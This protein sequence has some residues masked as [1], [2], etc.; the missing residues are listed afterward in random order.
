M[1]SIGRLQIHQTDH[2]RQPVATTDGI[3]LTTRYGV[4]LG[5]FVFV[6]VFVGL[7]VAC[8]AEEG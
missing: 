4:V 2:Y 7:L 1:N 5:V 3:H 8:W 6:F